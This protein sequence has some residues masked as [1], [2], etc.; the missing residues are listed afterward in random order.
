MST[1]DKIK[2]AVAAALVLGAVATAVPATE[3][4]RVGSSVLAMWTEPGGGGH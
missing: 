3:Q 2:R 4:A 1:A